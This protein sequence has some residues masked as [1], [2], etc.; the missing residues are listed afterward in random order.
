MRESRLSGSV[1]GVLRNPDPYSD[2]VTSHFSGSSEPLPTP[3]DKSAHRQTVV[4]GGERRCYPS[5]FVWS[6]WEAQPTRSKRPTCPALESLWSNRSSACR[7]FH[8][9]PALGQGQLMRDDHRRFRLSGMDQ[10]AQASVIGLD[11]RL[12]G[13]NAL[14]LDPEIAEVES[15]LAFLGELVCAARI[16][17]YEY[18]D[19]A[20]AAG[21]L[22][23]LHQIVHR[24]IGHL[25]AMHVAALV[26]DAFAA[27]IRALPTGQVQYLLHAAAL[28]VVNGDRANLFSQFQTILVRIDNKHLA[29]ALDEGRRGGHQPARPGPVPHDGV[30]RL[31]ARQFGRME[32]RGEDIRQHD[33]VVLLFPGVIGQHQ[34]V[35]VAVWHAQQ[36][37]LAAAVW[38][39]AREAVR[40][41]CIARIHG[42]AVA[43]QATFA[44]CA[45][46]TTNIEWKANHV[47]D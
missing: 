5:L 8:R 32:A 43:G 7:S 41:A 16:F 2:W 33:I 19:D 9:L 6:K 28:A 18:T 46:A 40:S 14:P 38:T 26:A 3:D 22:H 36:F 11:V 12:S 23:R 25:L 45:K 30:P 10:L 15:E 39:H 27:A 29:R 37:R 35:I 17:W 4:G 34:T 20:D 42:Q 44:V 31:D 13:G 47:T 24:Q 1:E 21:G